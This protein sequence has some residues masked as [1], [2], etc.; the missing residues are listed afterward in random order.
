[1]QPEPGHPSPGTAATSALP[2]PSDR[3]AAPAPDAHPARRSGK[4][5]PRSTVYGSFWLDETEFALPVDVIQE[6]VNAPDTYAT[7][8]MAP[9]HM[10]GLFCLRN[11]VIP[12]VDL[13]RIL[14]FPD[15]SEGRRKVVILENGELC[16]GL[17]FDDT[18]AIIHDTDASRV[19]FQRDANGLRDVVIEGVLKLE[20]GTRMVQLLDPLELLQIEKLPRVSRSGPSENHDGHLG[21]RLN[22][23]SFQLGHTTCAI[24]LRFVQ[25]ITDMPDLSHSE[26][27][28]GYI[29]GNIELRGRTMPVV[30]F[31]GMIGREAPF[32][33]DK[34]A[35]EARKLLVLDLPEG[36]V[37]LLVYSIDSIMSFYE[38]DVLPFANV[39]LPRHDIVS[40]CLVKED[41][42]IVILLDHAALLRDEMLIYAARSCQEVYPSQEIEARPKEQHGHLERSTY[43]LFTVDIEMGFDISCVSEVIERP[44]TLL[45]PPYALE[46]VDGI[47]NLRG[48]LI[49]LI[50]LR[51]LYG[52]SDTGVQAERVL[53]FDANGRKYGIAVESIDEIVTTNA[54]DLLEVPTIRDPEA[55]RLVSGDVAG[56]LRVPSRAPGSN[57]VLVLN[58]E[59]V[60]SRCV[61]KGQPESAATAIL[62]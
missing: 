19:T 12:V 48:E 47:L 5:G 44:A 8:P 35:L 41:E 33:F 4:S 20:N 31:R 22:C 60:V 54:R 59:A 55:A 34:K 7:V 24:D 46:F 61:A 16:I 38:R 10:I 13:R 52:F 2:P 29:I 11:M 1:M 14:G 30:D 39:A 15:P 21:P 6:V 50:N 27:A 57:P 49:T 36:R 9:D 42:K 43:I 56:C 3:S 51:V 18:G 17:L 58:Q 26:L 45:K 62:D 40:G 53:I 32:R 28:H 37:G 25:E 23:I